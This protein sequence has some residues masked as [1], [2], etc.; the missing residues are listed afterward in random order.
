[1]TETPARARATNDP[2]A[3]AAAVAAA[4]AARA[5]P[6]WDLVL[7]RNN[8]ERLKREKFPLEIVNELEELGQRNYLDI[9]EEDMVRFQWYGLYQD[10]PKVG[11]FMLRIKAPAGIMTAAQYRAI[12]ELSTK[13]G[14]DYTELST[15]QNVQL[16][17]LQIKQFPE[18]FAALDAVGLTSLGGCGDS[19]RNITGCP[20]TGLDADELFDCRPQLDQVVQYFQTERDYFDLPRKHK[21]TISTC[22]A[23]CNAPEINCIVFIGTGQDG[24]NGFSLRVGGGLSSTPRLA[25]DLNVFVPQD[26]V[27]PCRRR[28]WTCGGLTCATG[29]HEPRHA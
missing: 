13:F 28:S 22:A 12:G 7:K 29:S 1:M 4:A 19:V 2:A 26:E 18:V 11:Y 17:W 24:R 15:R 8:V 6:D 23:Q 25:R 20:L 5:A 27:L 14:R 16:H 21:I 10:K 3:R 9:S